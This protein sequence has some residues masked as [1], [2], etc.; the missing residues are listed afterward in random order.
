M[1]SMKEKVNVG[2]LNVRTLYAAGKL[3]LLIK[4]LKHYRWDILGFSEVRW[5]K[6]GEIN[7]AEMTW[8]G[9]EVRHENGVAFLLS[10]KA[11]RA[12]LGYNPVSQILLWLTGL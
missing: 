1:K 5:T 2:T 10:Q 3:D 7:G 4:E 6:S 11:R 12:L 9:H 8:A